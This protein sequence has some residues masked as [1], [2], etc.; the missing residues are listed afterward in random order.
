MEAQPVKNG[1]KVVHTP[2]G[3]QGKVYA[4]TG[5]GRTVISSLDGTEPIDMATIE[6]LT[7]NGWRFGS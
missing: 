3:V 6:T 4:K 1:Q 7:A 5:D 2:S